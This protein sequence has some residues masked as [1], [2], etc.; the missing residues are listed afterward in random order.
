LSRH[1]LFWP[2]IIIVTALVMTLLFIL[3]KPGIDVGGIQERA[4]RVTATH[5]QFGDFHPNLILYGFTESPR[6]SILESAI[7]ADVTATHFFEGNYVTKGDTLIELDD[8]DFTLLVRQRQAAVDQLQAQIN[9]SKVQHAKEQSL[10]TQEQ[11]LLALTENEVNRQQSLQKREYSSRA[12]LEGAQ[13]NFYQQLLSVQNRELSIETFPYELAELEA[14]LANAKASLAKAKLDQQ[15]ARIKAPFNGRVTHLY[16][17]TGTHA[18]VGEELVAIYDTDS[19]EVRAQIPNRY[20]VNAY[21]ALA[22]NQLITAIAYIDGQQIDL[23]FDRLASEVSTRRGGV[24]GIFKIVNQNPNIAIGRPVR[25]IVTLPLVTDVYQVPSSALYGNDRIYK[26]NR[27]NRLETVAIEQL[28]SIYPLQP[29]GQT[30]ILL[31]TSAP[32]SVDDLILTTQLP[33]TRQNLLVDPIN[34]TQIQPTD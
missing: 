14:E 5:P 2:L 24:D 3:I 7:E 16:V 27:D 22:E 17:S 4:W 15:R 1:R 8:R 34:E 11:K 25:L 26:I 13:Q 30:S 31:R 33:N 18:N 12:S 20:V 6:H 19:V 23:Q 9:R 29:T 28:G 21:R 32:L 10:L